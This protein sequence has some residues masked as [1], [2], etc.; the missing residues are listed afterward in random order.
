MVVPVSN[1][2]SLTYLWVPRKKK[3]YSKPTVLVRHFEFAGLSA[4]S[5]KVCQRS[6]GLESVGASLA[7]RCVAWALEI[8]EDSL[9]GSLPSL[10]SLWSL[11][12]GLKDALLPE[13]P[14][15]SAA[16]DWTKTHFQALLDI[17]IYSLMSTPSSI[18][19]KHQE[20]LISRDAACFGSLIPGVSKQYQSCNPQRQRQGSLSS[21]SRAEPSNISPARTGKPHASQHVSTYQP[22]CWTIHH[23][24]GFNWYT[25]KLDATIV[26]PKLICISWI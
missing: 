2:T 1:S 18:V 12:G 26:R 13:C 24:K 10:W 15:S 4:S 19:Q 23:K 25:K 11:F 5:T 7:L 22:F 17:Y 16:E 21:D 9:P 3:T 14:E 8:S 20:H 6:P